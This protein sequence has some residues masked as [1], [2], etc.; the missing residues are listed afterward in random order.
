ML[1]CIGDLALAGHQI[2]AHIRGHKMGHAIN[3]RALRT[4]FADRS[5]WEYVTIS[6]ISQHNIP[7]DLSM[8]A[9]AA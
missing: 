7:V 2:L 8:Q 6:E 9:N 5:N 1:D 4:L 3:N